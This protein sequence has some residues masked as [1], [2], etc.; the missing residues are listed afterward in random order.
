[1][2]TEGANA[3]T[4]G[5]RHRERHQSNINAHPGKGDSAEGENG[6]AQLFIWLTPCRS[7]TLVPLFGVCVLRL[8]SAHTEIYTERASGRAAVYAE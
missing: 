6:A 5:A 1:M 2:E 8:Q 4:K 7:R 3:R